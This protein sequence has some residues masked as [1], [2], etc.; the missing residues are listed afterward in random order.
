MSDPIEALSPSAADVVLGQLRKAAFTALHK[1]GF[2]PKKKPAAPPSGEAPCPECGGAM[3]DHK[4]P[5]AAPAGGAAPVPKKPGAP[6]TGTDLTQAGGTALGGADDESDA[7]E[8][9][10]DD[11]DGDGMPDAGGEEEDAIEALDPEGAEEGDEAEELPA[12]DGDNHGVGDLNQDGST[13][14]LVQEVTNLERDYYAA[15]G[16]HGDGPKAMVVL[17]RYHRAVRALVRSL[18][19]GGAS[20]AP[21]VE[22]EEGAD[23]GEEEDA[24]EALDGAPAPKG[25]APKKPAGG[26]PKPPAAA[27]APPAKGAAPGGAEKPAGGKPAVVP[28]APKA[29]EGDEPNKPDP[30]AP[31]F[32]KSLSD[33]TSFVNDAPIPEDYLVD[34]FGAFVE[35]AFE[36]E[37]R[38]Q[39]HQWTQM[40]PIDWA[41]CVLHEFVMRLPRNA[42]FRRIGEKYKI[43]APL[44]AAMLLEA[45]LVKPGGDTVGLDGGNGYGNEP[46]E[47]FAGDSAYKSRSFTWVKPDPL[48]APGITLPE[49]DLVVFP[50]STADDPFTALRKGLEGQAARVAAQLGQSPSTPVELTDT[51]ASRI[52]A[53]NVIARARLVTNLLT[54]LG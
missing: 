33:F 14:S 38:E 53:A 42:N 47:M 54:K 3:A 12:D 30:V 19:G 50:E 26:P 7:I 43:D 40:T 28:S 16:L 41:K 25:A 13:D 32:K 15:K 6:S 49:R 27:G 10:A 24:I 9:L 35:E 39:A 4:A 8:D 20:A 18:A 29:V 1:A 5:A 23:D 51:T 11:M 48:A 2:A 34:Y 31:K 46:V 17:D 36:Q 22:G 44:I 52:D 37:R 21:P 45:K